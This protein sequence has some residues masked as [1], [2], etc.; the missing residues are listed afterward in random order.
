MKEDSASAALNSRPLIVAGFHHNVIEAV[1]TFEIFRSRRVWQ[2]HLAIVVPV[3][4][5]LAP[6]PALPDR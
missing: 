2:F 4:N 1:G 6:A 5:V 3:A